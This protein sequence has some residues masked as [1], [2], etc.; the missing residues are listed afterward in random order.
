ML[1]MHHMLTNLQPK[2]PPACEIPKLKIKSVPRQSVSF[3]AKRKDKYHCFT[4]FSPHRI[5][6]D[7]KEYPTSEHLYQAFKYMDYRP[8]IAEA[9]RTVSKSRDMA[10]KYSMARIEHQDPN[11]ERLCIAKME[12]AIWHKFSQHP[13]IKQILLDTGDAELVNTSKDEFWGMGKNKKGRNELGKT[14]E[15]VR[16]S[17]RTA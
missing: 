17:L 4:N 9:I 2:I 10:F 12:I 6:Y 1:N 5:L 16:A 15:R 13:D 11:W 7:G 14:L 8:D 3:H